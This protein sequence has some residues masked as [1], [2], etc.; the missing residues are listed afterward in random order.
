MGFIRKTIT[1]TELLDRSVKT[2]VDEL[3]NSNDRECSAE[4]ESTRTALIQGEAS[5]EA[6]YFDAESFKRKM[7]A[8]PQSNKLED[9]ELNAIADSRANHLVIKVSLD[10]L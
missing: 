9:L 1:L 3:H 5:G 8:T 2:Q 7:R 10:D 6:K 4:M